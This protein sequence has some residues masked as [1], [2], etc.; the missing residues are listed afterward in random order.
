MQFFF[1]IIYLIWNKTELLHTKELSLFLDQCIPCNE[2]DNLIWILFKIKEEV[3]NIPTSALL[4]LWYLNLKIQK[5]WA[6]LFPAKVVIFGHCWTSAAQIHISQSFKSFRVYLEL[7]TY[8]AKHFNRRHKPQ[9]SSEVK[10]SHANGCRTTAITAYIEVM[11]TVLKMW[12][13]QRV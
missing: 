10:N 4:L 5:Q 2:M 8:T 7:Q 3:C 6:I 13:C 9:M 12:W 1:K 11:L